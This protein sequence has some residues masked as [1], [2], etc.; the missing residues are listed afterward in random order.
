VGRLT[1]RISPQNGDAPV[2]PERPYRL[3]LVYDGGSGVQAMLMDVR[4]APGSRAAYL[5]AEAVD[6]LAMRHDQLIQGGEVT[7]LG[8]REQGVG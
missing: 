8:G 6:A 1:A 7:G 3:I 2:V 4:A 5:K